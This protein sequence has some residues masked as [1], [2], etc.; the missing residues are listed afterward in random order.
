MGKLDTKATVTLILNGQQ[1][2]TS[3][4][5]VTSAVN[6]TRAALS[7]M[8]AEDDPA[9][10]RQ[11]ISELGR[12]RQAQA[13][14]REEIFGGTE[15]QKG[16][17]QSFKDGFSEMAGNITAGTLI[18]KGVSGAL[19]FVKNLWNGAEAAYQEAVKGQAQL[20]AAL[21]STGGVAG[22]TKESLADLAG[23]L[24]ELTGIDD[25]VIS[26][27]E[28]ILLTFTNIRG[29]IYDDALPAIVDMTA[30]MNQGEVSMEGIQTTSIQVGKAL[31]DPIKGLTALAK[32]GVTFTAQ[33]KE[34]V[35]SLVES[36]RVQEA[37]VII[38]KELQ[39]EFGGTAK[40]IADT[41]VGAMQK[42]ETRLGNIQEN[43]GKMITT[44]KGGFAK[45]FDPFLS[46]VEKISNSKMANTIQAE[47]N[48][49]NTLVNA[50]VV[51]NENQAVRN[52][53]IAELQ[54]K[55]PD[56]LGNISRE[57][58][59]NDLLLRR[60]KAVND[61]YRQKIF[62]AVNNDKLAD[63]EERRA[64]AMKE[65]LD[66]TKFLVDATG[67][68]SDQLASM[69][70]KQ[71][72]ALAKQHAKSARENVPDSM[73]MGA[74]AGADT[75]EA[76]FNILANGKRVLAGL[77]KEQAALTAQNAN[78]ED[79]IK[80][81]K[82][83]NLDKE[84][85]KIKEKLK[86]DKDPDKKLADQKELARLEQQ[87]K[88]LLGII[89]KPT[90]GPTGKGS[91]GESEAEK[92]IK[93]FAEL[94]KAHKE[95]EAAAMVE[96][97]SASQKEIALEDKKYQDLIDKEREFLG[98]KGVS[99]AQQAD[100]EKKISDLENQRIAAVMTLREKQEKDL[101]DKIK[102][103]RAGLTDN[104]KTELERQ[105]D[106]INK[107]YDEMLGLGGDPALIASE[108]AAAIA[109]VEI[110]EAKR[111]EAE[112]AKIDKEAAEKKDLQNKKEAEDAKKLHDDINDAIKHA[113]FSG[114]QT[115]ADGVFAIGQQNR[116]QELNAE[117]SKLDK[118]REK[119][120]SVRGLTEEQKKKI[121]EKY[122]KKEAE[123]KLKAWKA[124]QAA[125]LQQAI[126]NT[127]LAV[128]MALTSAPWPFNLIS[129]GGAALAGAAQ[130][131]LIAGAKAPEFEKGG[132]IQGPRHSA[133]GVNLVNNQTGKAIGE[134]E[135]GE[136]LLVL[137]RNTTRN[138]GPLINELLY[139]SQYR[140]G[141]PVT[142]DNRLATV[143]A[144]RQAI[145]AGV[146]A[147]AS[148]TRAG[149]GGTGQQANSFHYE[150]M[151]G[152]L[153][154]IDSSFDAWGKKPWEFNDRAFQ[155]YRDRKQAI[156]DRAKV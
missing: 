88:G 80:K 11:L 36:N 50:I 87:K 57:D 153:Q 45:A 69:S 25:D 8:R 4:K 49:L 44:V 132:I 61:E 22:K 37:Q 32:V 6:A 79:R 95:F 41:D 96:T 113:A 3:L 60:L 26:K 10:Y 127:A 9:R 30:A 98:K 7:N 31:N 101:A 104:L 151:I 5:E 78:I 129:A 122:D 109:D 39:K 65:Q 154:K 144:S 38:L 136:A 99:K 156:I 24:M 56:F 12:L 71:L 112:K 63:I 64:K 149:A 143:P 16:F 76:V 106:T 92:R 131:A 90:G 18:Y 14:L 83:A 43:L 70:E 53:L 72:L 137:S 134:V 55:Y 119:E 54:A 102:A 35:K 100:I 27:G 111:A 51:T 47:Q 91:K 133:G 108:R 146:S 13:S 1:T 15:A 52:S 84:I 34:Q 115:I 75:A 85:A 135:G 20:D 62:L 77:D 128:T 17:F 81:E 21:K 33:Q 120:L 107:K 103:L 152:L 121:N 138:N 105:K 147:G 74:G 116:D 140:N 110:A 29:K 58:A 2:K 148:G 68:T 94:A 19:D 66:A 139:N 118:Q 82:L 126:I 42:M 155:E 124:E 125:K 48:E 93:E 114:A 59:A 67:K 86:L 89:D 73:D 130:V 117:L 145:S 150:Q 97:L 142:V 141:A 46:W 23:G 40:A 123:L 28:Q